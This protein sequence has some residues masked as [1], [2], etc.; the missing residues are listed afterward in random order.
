M[1][2]DF[3]LVSIISV[4]SIFLVLVSSNLL[5]CYLRFL[6]FAVLVFDFL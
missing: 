1:F 3:C 6:F 5:R 4:F 2:E